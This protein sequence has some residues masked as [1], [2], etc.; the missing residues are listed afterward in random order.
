[1]ILLLD[2]NPCV[3]G[4]ANVFRFVYPAIGFVAIRS[5]HGYLYLCKYIAAL[6]FY[7]GSRGE[8]S[9]DE[10]D[11]EMLACGHFGELSDGDSDDCE[12]ADVDS[13]FTID[14]AVTC[15]FDGFSMQAQKSHH[16][17]HRGNGKHS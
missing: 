17:K 2:S 4:S 5:I 13:W 12:M 16:L 14:D 1:M 10:A 7:Q 11:A 9:D 15:D 3:I 6:N 8:S